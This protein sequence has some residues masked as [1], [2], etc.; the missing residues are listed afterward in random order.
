M[1]RLDGSARPLERDTLD[2][3]GIERALCQKHRR[4]PQVLGNLLGGVFEDLD[5][6]VADDLAFLLG[7]G[8]AGQAAQEQVRGI[9]GVEADVEMIAKGRLHLLPLAFAQQAVVD[10]D[11]GEL[12]AQGLVQQHRRHRRIDPA[13]E[14]QDHVLV[15]DLLADLL[16]F[17][18]D[19]RGGRPIALSA[20]DAMGEVFQNLAAMIGMDDL[21]VELHAVV[22]QHSRAHGGDGRVVGVGDDLVVVRQAG[23]VVAVAHPDLRAR[24]DARQQIRVVVD[25]EVGASE[26][27]AAGPFDAA[28][29]GVGHR[30]EAVAD[31]QNRH[32]R[33]VGAMHLEEGRVELGSTLV[34]DRT[35]AARENQPEGPHRFHLSRIDRAGVDLRKNTGLAHAPRNELRILRAEIQ[36]DNS[37]VHPT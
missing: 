30:L 6:G 26:L 15:A 25:V 33:A 24:R 29:E 20:A 12:V 8:H 9:D 31:A 28:A 21:G 19:E 17:L 27:A 13:G 18:L 3:V 10:E 11:T 1:V 16:F 22:R 35:G 37:L 4:A 5:E 14:T 23:Q 7:L 32:R 2:H 36:D 34:V